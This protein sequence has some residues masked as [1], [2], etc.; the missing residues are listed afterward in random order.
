MT[1]GETAAR[2]RYVVLATALWSFD[3]QPRRGDPLLHSAAP[4]A[5]RTLLIELFKVP[6]EHGERDGGRRGPRWAHQPAE[7]TA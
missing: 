2:A 1:C 6:S 4:A 3:E 5:S 7:P